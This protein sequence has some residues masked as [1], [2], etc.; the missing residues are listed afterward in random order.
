MVS[1]G[2]MIFNINRAYSYLTSL[3]LLLVVCM[4]LPLTAAVVVSRYLHIDKKPSIDFNKKTVQDIGA[5]TVILKTNAQQ[6]LFTP[7]LTDNNA[8]LTTPIITDNGLSFTFSSA[9]YTQLIKDI[10]SASSTLLAAIKKEMIQNKQ[11]HE[12]NT[13]AEISDKLKNSLNLFTVNIIQNMISQYEAGG[14]SAFTQN[15]SIQ[16]LRQQIGQTTFDNT[17][18]SNTKQAMLSELTTI[19]KSFSSISRY[20]LPINILDNSSIEAAPYRALYY[21]IIKLGKSFGFTCKPIDSTFLQKTT[22]RLNNRYFWGLVAGAGLFG[23]WKFGVFGKTPYMTQSQTDICPTS[24]VPELPTFT[25]QSQP[26]PG[27]LKS[28]QDGFNK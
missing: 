24:L 28:F 9:I 23:L 6:Q 19:E 13:D 17:S 22:R 16:S 12:K 20:T 10:A 21:E 14:S 26:T 7:E 11:A 8:T 4:Q 1:G 15:K 18:N 3:A 2:H 5:F 27:F 25:P